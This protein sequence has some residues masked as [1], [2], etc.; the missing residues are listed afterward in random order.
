MNRERLIPLKLEEHKE[1]LPLLLPKER[2]PLFKTDRQDVTG[3]AAKFVSLLLRSLTNKNR[4]PPIEKKTAMLY[5]LQCILCMYAEDIDLL[6]NKIF[7]RLIEE[8]LEKKEQDTIT[9]PI[10]T[11]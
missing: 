1:P 7:T 6:P 9:Y 8:C 5:C 2:K 3:E 4:K 11:I 10:P